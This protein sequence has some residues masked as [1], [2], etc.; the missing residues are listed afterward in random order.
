MIPADAIRGRLIAAAPTPFD[1]SGDVHWPGLR[2]LVSFLAGAGL[3]GV[4]VGTS[5]GRGSQ[6]A[7]NLWDR[8]ISCW[9]EGLPESILLMASVGAA[10]ELRRT[11]DV[12]QAA[13]ARG[14]RAGQLGA[15]VL[16]VQPPTVFRSRPESDRLILEY[17]S[18]LAETGLPLLASYRR[19]LVGGIAYGPAVLAQLLA[20]P[21]VLGVEIATIDGITTFQQVEGLSHALAKDKLV[22]SGEDRFL[23]YSLI[24]GADAAIVGLAAVYPSVLLE[25]LAAHHSAEASLFLKL[26]R[27]VDALARPKPRTTPGDR[28]SSGPRS[29]DSEPTGSVRSE[30]ERRRR[31]PRG[32]APAPRST[33]TAHPPDRRTE[34]PRHSRASRR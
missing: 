25:L 18:A 20:R 22:I 6:L 27:R 1:S 11:P 4:A 19:E 33:R 15:D 21:E 14:M 13:V 17:F 9:R 32:R 12:I 31:E 10:P 5:L 26:V 34:H 28:V 7:S 23:G 2:H 30:R 8:V 3:G 29:I 16:L 24:C